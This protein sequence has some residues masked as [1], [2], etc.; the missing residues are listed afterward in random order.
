MHAT[1]ILSSPPNFKRDASSA[2][3]VSN[4]C[5]SSFEQEFSSILRVKACILWVIEAMEDERTA[6]SSRR[7]AKF[8]DKS[9]G[10]ASSVCVYSCR[11]DREYAVSGVG[12]WVKL[13]WM[14]LGAMAESVLVV[15]TV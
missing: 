15:V 4:Q 1:R 5:R 9:S 10:K 8:L 14:V 3:W 11:R 7:S 2:I 6:S 13:L 12:G